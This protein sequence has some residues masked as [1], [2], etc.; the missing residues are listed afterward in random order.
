VHAR[1]GTIAFGF[2]AAPPALRHT[3]ALLHL[4]VWADIWPAG[5]TALR[6]WYGCPSIFIELLPQNDL[7]ILQIHRVSVVS[8]C[9]RTTDQNTVALTSATH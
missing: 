1:L 3:N 5:P 2:G 7:I 4:P 9:L 6:F 8:H